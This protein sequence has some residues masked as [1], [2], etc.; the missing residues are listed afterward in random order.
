MF[1]FLYFASI[2]NDLNC[3]YSMFGKGLFFFGFSVFKNL[4]IA[5]VVCF[6][7]NKKT[8]FIISNLGSVIFLI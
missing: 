5:F 8:I 2:I 7:L 6:I 4:K 1:E 3:L